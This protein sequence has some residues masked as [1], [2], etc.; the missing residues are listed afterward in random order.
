MI[1]VPVENIDD[2][3]C[4]VVRDTNT[5]RAYKQSPQV[6]TTVNYRDFYINSHYLY[7]DG[8]Q[9]FSNYSTSLPVCLD[10]AKMTNSY[11]YRNDLADILVIALILIGTVWFLISKL[12]KNLLRGRKLY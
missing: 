3:K 4:Y 9:S 8:S 5:L 12:V 2:Y 6:N 10:N 7:Q 1:Y 11:L